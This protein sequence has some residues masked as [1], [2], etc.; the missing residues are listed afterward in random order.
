MKEIDVREKSI[1][2]K[3]KKK[4]PQLEVAFVKRKKPGK[5]ALVIVPLLLTALGTGV[6]L[7]IYYNQKP[8]EP[9]DVIKQDTG[10]NH[11]IYLVANDKTT[12]PLTVK[13][14]KRNTIGENLKDLFNLLKTDSK[15]NTN[16]IK[17]IVPAETKVNA[18]EVFNDELILDVSEEFLN[19]EPTKEVNILESLVYTFSEFPSINMLSIYVNGEKLEKMPQKNT[20]VPDFLQKNFGINRTTKN[21]EELTN[22]NMFNIYYTKKYDDVSYLIPVTQYVENEGT[23]ESQ[24][25]KAI[26]N[27]APDGMVL[28]TQ[29]N[30][31]SETQDDKNDEKV[32]LNLK[33]AALKEEGVVKKDVYEMVALTFNDLEKDY[34]ISFEIEG[35]SLVVEG[36]Q[37]TKNFEVANLI[38]NQK[39]I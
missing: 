16:S 32:N 35:E 38:Y 9:V 8:N 14:K 15:A 6:G 39:E 22:K 30:Y 28:A 23:V 33:Q 2:E 24:F 19:Y 20:L 3:I 27:S 5:A 36:I 31:I 17:G 37:D 11:R 18:I 7:G 13:T 1:V 12:V 10:E 34:E 25:A 29:Y 4:F 21:A 26:N